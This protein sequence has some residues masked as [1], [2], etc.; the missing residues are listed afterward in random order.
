MAKRMPVSNSAKRVRQLKKWL[1]ESKDYLLDEARGHIESEIHHN[2]VE[3]WVDVRIWIG[4]NASWLGG[5][6]IVSIMDGDSQGWTLIV[7][8]AKCRYWGQR[9]LDALGRAGHRPRAYRRVVALL[10]AYGLCME[11]RSVAEWSGQRLYTSLEDAGLL[12]EEWRFAALP[13]FM[14]QLYAR[15]K[16][17]DYDFSRQDFGRF[18]IY[19]EVLDAWDDENRLGKAI[20]EACDYHVRRRDG[21]DPSLEFEYGPF[22]EFPAEILAIYKVRESLGLSTPLVEHPLLDTPLAHPPAKIPEYRDR[23]LDLIA[24]KFREAFPDQ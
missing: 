20:R 17:L 5:Q 6:G 7:G 13:G 21:D 15:Q 22:D 16:S 9:I 24:E 18:S 10:L 23:W 12:N 4:Q 3:T 11:D 1:N 2:T 8:S 19:Q 14:V